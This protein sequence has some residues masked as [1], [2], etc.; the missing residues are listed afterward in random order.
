MGQIFLVRHGQA[1]FGSENYDQLSPL[2][3]EQ[4]TILGTWFARCGQRFD[5]V[6]TGALK[7]HQ[8]TAQACMAELPQ[9][10]PSACDGGFNEYDHDEIMRAHRPEFADTKEIKRFMA[11]HPDAK[12]V[13]QLEFEKAMARWMSG[14]HDADYSETWQAFQQRCIAALTR[15][16]DPAQSSQRIA[17]F[18]SGGTISALCQ[19]VLG[20]PDQHVYQLNWSLVNSAVTKLR[21]QSH[22]DDAGQVVNRISLSYLNSYAHLE[23]LS[24]TDSITYR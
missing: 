2:G 20:L 22:R 19:H 6:V 4:S 14:L 7:R 24:D 13:F 15:L 18:T 8:Q 3:V 5:R 23:C 21:F 12:R 17:V 16:I 1:S 9:D 11:S 10:A